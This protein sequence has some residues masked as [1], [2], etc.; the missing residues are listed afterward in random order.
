MDINY[1]VIYSKLHLHFQFL[2]KFLEI[3]SKQFLVYFVQNKLLLE[4]IEKNNLILKE[5]AHLKNNNS[6]KIFFNNF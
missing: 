4:G 6:K 3:M 1:K 2:L 5:M